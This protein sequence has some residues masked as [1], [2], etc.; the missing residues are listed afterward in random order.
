MVILI[1]DD[2]SF[3][4]ALAENLRDDGY[5][6]CE[7]A[8]PA[9]LP[10]LETLSGLG[11]VI[12]DYEF[13]RANGLAFA[14]ALHAM[15]PQVPVVLITAFPRWNLASQTATRQFVHL[16]PKPLDYDRLREILLALSSS[17]IADPAHQS[18]S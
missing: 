13:P 18:C 10:P 5:G 3:R 14:D 7:Y 2:E 16:L 4:G 9:D 6:V 17:E 15:H 11:V 8:T 1:D 12:M